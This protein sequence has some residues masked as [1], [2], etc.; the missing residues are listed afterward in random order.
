M[1]GLKV[2]GQVIVMGETNRPNALDIALLIFEDLIEKLI[3]EYLMK[4]AD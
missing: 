1:D 3:L 2:R 4:Q